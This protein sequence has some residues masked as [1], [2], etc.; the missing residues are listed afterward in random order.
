M[1]HNAFFRANPSADQTNR[2]S[3]AT[4]ALV[5]SAMLRC[6]D[7]APTPDRICADILAAPAVWQK[8]VEED[9]IAIPD[10]AFRSG[11]RAAKMDKPVSPPKSRPSLPSMHPDLMEALDFFI[12]RG[13]ATASEESVKRG[14]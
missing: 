14:I 13:D 10:I 7:V 5:E 6:W 11:K 4:P 8:I 2:I 12:H 9:G 1:V 3:M